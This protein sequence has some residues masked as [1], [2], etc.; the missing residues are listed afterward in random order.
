MSLSPKDAFLAVAILSTAF[1]IEIAT[2][3]LAGLI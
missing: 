2:F 1:L 3:I